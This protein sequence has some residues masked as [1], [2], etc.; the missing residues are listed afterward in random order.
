MVARTRELPYKELCSAAATATGSPGFAGA[1]TKWA[2]PAGCG[3]GAQRFSYCGR[4]HCG[5]GASCRSAPP[6][7][8]SGLGASGLVGW[9]GLGI[10]A[11]G[12]RAGALA[13][14]PP[15]R[16]PVTPRAPLA[17]TRA[18]HAA[19][20]AGGRGCGVPRLQGTRGQAAVGWPW[21]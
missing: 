18:A 19:L 4:R 11:P 14:Q 15:P 10:H 16:T 5:G 20:D 9:A 12:Q 1:C 13:P 6:A 2:G 7:C 3:R 21:S 17:R 8:S